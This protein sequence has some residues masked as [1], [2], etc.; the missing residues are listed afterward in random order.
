MGTQDMQEQQQVQ[1]TLTGQKILKR[2]SNN[3]VGGTKK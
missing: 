2:P 1:A 3:K